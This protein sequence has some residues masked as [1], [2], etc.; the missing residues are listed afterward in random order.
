RG[1]RQSR[2]DR[3]AEIAAHDTAEPDRDLR[4]ERLVEPELGPDL[5]DVVR[6]R[7]VAGDDDGGIARRDVQEREGR[8]GH[9]VHDG[10]GGPQ[11]AGK[12]REHD[13]AIA[14]FQKTGAGNWSTPLTD[15]RYAV[16]RTHW[17]NGTYSTSSY[18]IFWISSASCFC[19]TL[20]VART[21]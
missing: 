16:G 11:S 1:H 2:V 3:R 21:H 8:D 13:Q 7:V 9:D 15:L 4:M 10:N 12:L 14:T 6:R 17:P 19:R 5:R 20:S 18:A